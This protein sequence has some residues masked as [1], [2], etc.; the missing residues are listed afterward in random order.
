MKI[1]KLLNKSYKIFFLIFLIFS[2]NYLYSTEP[3]EPVDIWKT[4]STKKKIK[5]K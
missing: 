3:T 4:D 1:S 2:Q 5:M